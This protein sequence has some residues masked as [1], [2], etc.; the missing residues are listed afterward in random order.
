VITPQQSALIE[1]EAC[2]PEHLPHYVAAVS[3]C[4]P[5][6]LDEF[7]I[8]TQGERL[9]LVGYPLGQ[10]FN[11]TRLQATIQQAERRFR[12]AVFSLI[13]P[14]LP[15]DWHPTQTQAAASPFS[16]AQPASPAPAADA[17]YR[18]ELARLQPGK[19]LRN[20]LNR[21]ARGLRIETAASFGKEHHS[22][23]QDFLRSRTLEP[24]ARS[25]FQRLDYY[26]RL[27]SSRLLEA[28]DQRSRLV[29]FDL[30]DFS[31]RR[32]AFYLFNFRSSRVYVPGASDLLLAE[33]IEL[34]RQAGKAFINLGLGIH[35][36]VAF[37][38]TK[39]GAAPFLPYQF[40]L[41]QQP[42]PDLLT[43]LL[44]QFSF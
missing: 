28:R 43:A 39:W 42:G 34:S 27:P 20:L 11:L 14:Q 24:A 44:D 21:A 1:E 29:A 8:Y 16:A 7:I 40:A 36:G 2:I 6:L 10:P 4:E 31:S 22:L 13:A 3:P 37:F 15:P 26:A 38:K 5:F 41:R 25:I 12:P 19:K 9:V 35:P 23:V 32:Y 17:Y 18:L 33:I 30:A